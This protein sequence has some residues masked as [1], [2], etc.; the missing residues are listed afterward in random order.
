MTDDVDAPAGWPARG[1]VL[2]RRQ[3][4][5]DAFLRKLYASFRAEELASLPWTAARKAAFLDSQFDLQRIHFDRF[6]AGADFLIVE[7]ADRPIGRLYL[8]KAADGFLV[9]DIGFLPDRRGLGLGREMLRHLH[10]CAARA[11][12]RR[13]WLNV[14]VFNPGAQRLYERLGFRVIH[15]DGGSH[16]TLEWPVS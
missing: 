11:G 7:E 5:D 12:A 15:D 14:S 1:L 8:N 3:E 4:G 13:V 16:R 2:R 9:I 6:H 10:V